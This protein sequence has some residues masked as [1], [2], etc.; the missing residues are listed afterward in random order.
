MY[1]YEKILEGNEKMEITAGGHTDFFIDDGDTAAGS[2]CIGCS[3][4]NEA[5]YEDI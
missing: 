3:F 2:R 1:G 4:G 5:S